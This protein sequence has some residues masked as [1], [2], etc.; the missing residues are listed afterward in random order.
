M[1]NLIED[2]YIPHWATFLIGSAIGTITAWLLV[3]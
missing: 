3:G 2:L 1:K